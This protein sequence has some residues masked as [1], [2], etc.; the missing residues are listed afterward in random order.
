MVFTKR[1]MWRWHRAGVSVSQFA[2]ALI[3]NL[4]VKPILV[5]LLL[6]LE[7]ATGRVEAKPIIWHVLQFLQSDQS[8]PY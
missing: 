3:L 6:L 1:L 2:L 4:S 8:T 5:F 7:N